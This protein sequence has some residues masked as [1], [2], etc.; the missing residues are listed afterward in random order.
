MAYPDY[1]T[2]AL[3][4]RPGDRAALDGRL[5]DLDENLRVGNLRLAAHALDQLA[6]A[7]AQA[8]ETLR[9]TPAAPAEVTPLRL[10]S[11]GTTVRR[12]RAA[13]GFA[14][15]ALDAIG[16]LAILAGV[17]V[18]WWLAGGRL[19]DGPALRHALLEGT[20][21]TAWNW[22]PAAAAFAALLTAEIGEGLGAA[23]RWARR[24]R[25]TTVHPDRHE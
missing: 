4:L 11:T 17:V 25:I 9:D 12:R 20:P 23:S 5:R 24:R 2:T 8:A 1:T 19:A 16:G 15:H 13:F 6:A 14:Q 21:L 22:Q 10:E 3:R 7:A 18:V